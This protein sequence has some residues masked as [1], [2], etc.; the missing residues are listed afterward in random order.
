MPA[1]A[2]DNIRVYRTINRYVLRN[3][4]CRTTQ[5]GELHPIN[6]MNHLLGGFPHLERVFLHI[7]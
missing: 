2:F 4:R 3:Q 6:T 1:A 5:N 7:G